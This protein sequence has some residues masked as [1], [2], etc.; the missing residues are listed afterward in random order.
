MTL[1]L[2]N[3]EIKKYICI[4][5]TIIPIIERAFIALSNK[6][7]IMP[8][9]M[10]LDIEENN[11]EVDVK[12]AYIKGYNNFAVKI[13]PGFFNNY[14][15]GLPSTSGMMNLFNSKTGL[16]ES[17]L[18]DNGYLT[19]VRTAIAGAISIKYLS[20]KNITDVGIIGTGTQARM[21][22]EALMLVRKPKIVRIWS[23]NKDNINSFIREM[24]KNINCEITA[25][26]NPKLITEKSNLI[27]TTTPSKKPIIL[28]EWLHDDLHIT[29]MGSDAEEKNEIDPKIIKNSDFYIADNIKQTSILG[30]LHHA[31]NAKLVPSKKKIMELGDIIKNKMIVRSS[32]KQITICDLTGTGVQDTAIAIY[33]YQIAKK[34]KL[35]KIIV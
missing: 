3:S 18:L 27:I 22:L 10:R 25:G 19:N 8:P 4:D 2:K 34:N 35:G 32:H 21:Q 28:N 24:S 13:S 26:K 33:A 12:T 29:A 31:I 1:L 17:V 14:K 23:R 6:K 11:G 30:E 9:I 5:K 15:L 20:N 16:L 7:A